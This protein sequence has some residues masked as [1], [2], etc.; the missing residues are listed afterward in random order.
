MFFA[1]TSLSRPPALAAGISVTTEP[2]GS[3]TVDVRTIDRKAHVAF[4]A[5]TFI[6]NVPPEFLREL[7]AEIAARSSFAFEIVN[8]PNPTQ[9]R[10]GRGVYHPHPAA[11][12]RFLY[13][14]GVGSDACLNERSERLTASM[15]QY[16]GYGARDIDLFFDHPDSIHPRIGG[17]LAM[18]WAVRELIVAAQ[19]L[20]D[21]VR[22]RGIQ[23]LAQAREL[24]LTIPL[25]VVSLPDLSDRIRETIGVFRRWYPRTRPGS[26][27]AGNNEGQGTL[28]LEVQS[29]TRMD[30]GLLRKTLTGTGTWNSELLLDPQHHAAAAKTLRR[31]LTRGWVMS[32]PSM[33]PQNFYAT[34][35]GDCSFAD[36]ED[37]RHLGMVGSE[38]RCFHPL[39][40]QWLTP[41]DQ[42]VLY[43]FGQVE[44]DLSGSLVL[45]KDAPRYA[46][47]RFEC[48]VEF[49]RHVLDGFKGA[50]LAREL[51]TLAPFFE[52]E[53]A[54]AIA[55]ELADTLDVASIEESARAFRTAMSSVTAYGVLD[56]YEITHKRGLEPLWNV[57]APWMLRQ[58]ASI[59]IIRDAIRT[60]DTSGLKGLPQYNECMAMLS[61]LRAHSADF[62]SLFLQRFSDLNLARA[63]R[64]EWYGE[65]KVEAS[66]KFTLE[67]LTEMLGKDTQAAMKA[68]MLN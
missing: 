3:G 9:A 23:T 50:V 43:I 5:D 63:G 55:Y 51:T 54:L 48:R 7:R 22:Q 47:E 41:A 19:I 42:R 40:S 49:L 25:C 44:R 52:Q 11:P 14:K 45:P 58:Q 31:I 57:A 64:W 27:W 56:E 4:T 35:S 30:G 16:P 36:G 29:S 39:G 20:G 66:R 21:A 46:A 53:I 65:G 28:L 17:A 34:K 13:C 8:E 15:S 33:H 10:E 68:V 32:R 18:R 2:G 37:L 6:G 61:A 62:A 59:Q 24:G 12:G 26:D 38:T 1:G 67:E 60:G